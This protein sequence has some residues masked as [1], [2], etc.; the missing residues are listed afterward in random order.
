[1]SIPKRATAFALNIGLVETA[2]RPFFK[3]SP[4]LAT[5]DFKI[6]TDGSAF[7][8]LATLPTV[9]PA[10]GRS[11]LIQLSAAEMTGDIIVV[12]GVD[13]AGAE[14]DEVLV[15]LLTTV[16]TVDDLV[17][18]TTPANTLDVTAAGNAGIDW[19]NVSSPTTTLA[20]TG[21]T[22]ATTQK[23]D[24][25]TI[26]TQA[27]TLA[28]GVTIPAATLA[29]TTNLTAGTITTAT[30]VT[31]VNGLAAG[32][33]TAASIAADAITAAKIADGAI[34]A[35]TFAAGAIDAAAIA[36]DAIGSAELAASAIT[37]IQAGL[38]TAA[39]LAT[40]QSDTDDIQARLP[41]ALVSGRID[42]SVGAMAADVLT[43]AAIATD[44]I[45]SAELAASA[46]TE[47]QA[48]LSTLDAAGVRT[49]V[50]LA[51]ANLDTQLSAL[52]SDT[53]N[54]QT[55]LPAALVSGR[56]DASVGAMA[57]GTITAAAIATDAI[58]ADALADGAITNATFAAETGQQTIR[59]NTAQAGGATSLTLDASASSVTDFYKNALL[60]LTGGTGVGQARFIT[61]YNGTTKVATVSAWATT[62]DVTSTFAILPLDSIPGATAPTAAA[63]ADAVWDEARADHTAAGSF[64]QG[65]ASV[66]GNVTGSVGSVASGGITSGSFTAGAIDAAAIATDAIGSAELAA[67]A[68]TEIQAGLSTLDAAGVRTAVGL[69]SA[70]LDTQLDALP[71]N[72]EL[73]T[74]LGTADDATLAAIAALNNLSQAN[75]R[76]AIGLAS[77][78]LDTQLAAVQADTDNL[79][80]RLP[81]AL[82]SGR[83]DANVGAMAAG[84]IL[85]ATFAA[86]AIDAAAIATDAIGVSELAA[87]AV[88]EIQAGLSTLDGAGVRAALGM[89]SADLD[90]QLDA[91]DDFL[92]TEVA[93]ILAAVDTEV[94]AIKAKTDTLPSGIQKNAALSNFSFLMVDSTDHV[95]PETGLTVTATRSLDGAAFA[96]CANAV[97]ELS[98][99]I[100]KI[101]LAAADLNGDVIVLRFA[102]VGADDRF[103]TVVTES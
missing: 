91:I 65:A 5:G 32:V 9:S 25:E 47:I 77:A 78:N 30:N 34:D 83:M 55:R 57:A 38:A 102:S 89:T 90:A 7:A 80:T 75:V 58:D 4:T 43:A 20:L 12:Q 53:D 40:V 16:V 23:V 82:V 37:E 42:A 52:Q 8:N 6:S 13:A 62:P 1:M 66:Q 64:G 74:A 56:I 60:Y 94:A 100:Y 27:V 39:A 15:T 72:A 19:A 36:T 76:T 59:S 28:G 54:L 98:N 84:T 26:K 79:Q 44:A 97:T 2:A 17:R 63:V 22:I 10:A 33:I 14:W 87:S 35:A 67:S 99:G 70:N 85:A 69:A 96:A 21:T 81:A 29:S 46:I 68:I 93:A 101:N 31:T 95:T 92:D 86:G 48:G 18:S 24:V 49:A 103:L 71:T 61:A 88:T 41:A 51:S 50:G 45:G 73:A 11:V 3:A